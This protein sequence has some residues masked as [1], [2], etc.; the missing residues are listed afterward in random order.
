MEGLTPVF[1]GLGPWLTS[2]E[3]AWTFIQVGGARAKGFV[4]FFFHFLMMKSVQGPQ[5]WREEQTSL[6]RVLP[7]LNTLGGQHAIHGRTSIIPL[8]SHANASDTSFLHPGQL[9]S[10]SF[11]CTPGP[12]PW[13]VLCS[14]KTP[15]SPATCTQ[16]SLESPSKSSEVAPEQVA[17]KSQSYFGYHE[18]ATRHLTLSEP[19]CL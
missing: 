13:E 11:L 12:C 2:P 14:D 4:F 8:P 17:Q 3:E 16:G 15:P 18:T 19:Q 1:Q 6:H 9:S 10:R 7:R 5:R